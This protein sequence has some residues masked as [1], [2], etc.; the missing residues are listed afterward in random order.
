M[1]V[2]YSQKATA[3]SSGLSGSEMTITSEES[4]ETLNVG[5]SKIFPFG[6][7]LAIR[8]KLPEDCRD[9]TLVC[10]KNLNI[11][12][13]SVSGDVAGT[14][15]LYNQG[16]IENVHVYESNIDSYRQG[17]G[18]CGGTKGEITIRNC[19]N[20]KSGRIKI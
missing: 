17:G 7:K 15:A 1:N 11:Y 2:T 16:M 3:K 19:A 5:E 13:A 12:N 18:I 14:I 4:G 9:F 20:A 8:F 10:I 6:R